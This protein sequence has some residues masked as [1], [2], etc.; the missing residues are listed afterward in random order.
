MPARDRC[1]AANVIG[2]K[3]AN[4]IGAKPANVIRDAIVVGAGLSGLVCARRLADA[5]LDV[6][7]LE[8]R[9]RVGGRLRA[10]KVGDTVVDLGGQW[11]SAGQPRLA[12]LAAALGVASVPQRREGR[13]FVAEPAAGV[14]AEIG[15]A[16]AQWRAVRSIERRA[17]AVAAARGGTGRTGGLDP[18]AEPA[19]DAA[20]DELSLAAWLR[21]AIANPIARDRIALHAEL[22][23]AADPAELSALCYFWIL[24][25]T[26]GFRPPGPELPGGGREHRFAGG[27]HALAARLA[28]GLDVRLA[29]PVLAIED[30]GA[31]PGAL[32]IRTA[33]GEHAARRAVLAVPPVLARRIEVALAPAAAR[34]AAASRAGAVVKCF[35]AYARPFWRDA[36]WS[37]EAFRPRGTV[38]A[39]VALDPDPILLAFV[40]GAHAAGWAARAPEDRRAEVLAT[41]AAQ[42]GDAAG[43]PVA[44]VE[45]DWAAEPWVAGCVAGLPPGVLSRGAAWGAPHGRVHV[46]GTESAAAWTGYMEGAIEAGE[47]A[48]AEVL[49]ELRGAPP[50]SGARR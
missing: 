3:P 47:R 40:V 7:V 17:R 32:R 33:R 11:M 4:V 22:V 28:T 44:Y 19:G 27:A 25:V 16:L 39:T 23:F 10:G 18:A 36:G 20:L 13:P 46:A 45:H 50:A 29:E 43:A 34:F 38:R 48:A 26:G 31:G 5:G 24:G 1:G 6:L 49:A 35:A 9:E 15:A 8:A 21:A 14:L 30:P 37:G 42:F 12:A 2:A 41:L